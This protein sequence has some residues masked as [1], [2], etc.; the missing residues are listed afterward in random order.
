LFK[1]KIIK[2]NKNTIIILILLGNIS[3]FSYFLYNKNVKNK[4]TTKNVL[5][6]YEYVP[7]TENTTFLDKSFDNNNSNNVINKNIIE[8]KQML[9]KSKKMMEEYNL[10]QNEII[11]SNDKLDKLISLNL[12]QNDKES[13]ILNND[14][15]LAPL[16][17]KIKKE[18]IKE[19]SKNIN[20]E[21][22][23][24][25]IKIVNIDEEKLINTFSL[26]TQ[27]KIAS[28]LP[29]V[30]EINTNIISSDENSNQLPTNSVNKEV[31]DEKKLLQNQ[32]SEIEKIINSIN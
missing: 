3:I 32:I 28:S 1:G 21:E 22:V 6:N 19:D 16:S 2:Y 23:Q 4:K 15:V 26:H 12:I 5:L 10:G 30:E 18:K 8:L 31:E 25:E 14:E 17:K 20:E 9:L 27:A 11:I 29:S 7:L 24:K 13:E